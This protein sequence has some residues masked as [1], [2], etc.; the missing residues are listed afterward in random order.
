[1][2]A[3]KQTNARVFDELSAHDSRIGQELLQQKV[4][5]ICKI[6]NMT[7]SDSKIAK[8]EG[9]ELKP[10]LLN[11]TTITLKFAILNKVPFFSF[12]GK[13]S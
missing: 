11:L 2:E 6:A 8:T 12:N 3:E 1:M 9:W 4:L 7:S 13:T 10:I 5:E